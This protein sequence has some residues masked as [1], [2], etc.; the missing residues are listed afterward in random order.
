M[1]DIPQKDFQDSPS[2]DQTSLATYLSR[3]FIM[4]KTNS[5]E[6]WNLVS[7]SNGIND[8]NFYHLLMIGSLTRF[9]ENVHD[10]LYCF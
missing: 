2:L 8:I 7:S 9:E 5:K 6:K 4:E 3:Y 1:A 10:I